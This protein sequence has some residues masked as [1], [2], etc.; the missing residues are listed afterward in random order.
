VVSRVLHTTRLELVLLEPEAARELT[1]GVHRNGHAWA[2][3]YPMASSLLR[4][5]LTAAAAASGRPL[6]RFGTYQVVR[7][8]DGAVIG[9]VGFLGP[10]DGTGAVH[11]GCGIIEGA[12]RQGYAT[13]ALVALLAWSRGQ[14]GLTCVVADTTRS[15]VGGQRLLERV[16]MHP[17]GEDGELLYYMT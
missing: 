1:A 6:G 10:P 15:N 2:P 9:D 4:A 14:N 13:E 12:R 5:E 17:V 8:D 16:G 3:G 11:V 7:R